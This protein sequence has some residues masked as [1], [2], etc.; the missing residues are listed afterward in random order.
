VALGQFLGSK[1]GTEILVMRADQG[2]GAPLKAG[3]Q[4]VIAGLAALSRDQP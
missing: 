3:T 2:D 4:L 1:R